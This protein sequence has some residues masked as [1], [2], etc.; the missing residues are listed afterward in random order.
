[1]FDESPITKQKIQLLEGRYGLYLN[2]GE[3]NASLPKGLAADAVTKEQALEL[4]AARAA[5]GP[6]KKSAR[7]KAPKKS[8]AKKRV[9]AARDTASSDDDSPAEDGAKPAK[10]KAVK[11]KAVKKKK[12]AKKGATKK[13]VKKKPADS[14]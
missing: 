13:S 4:L 9:V 7:R 11:K 12:A 8:P 5:L 6:S 14:E 10:K 2:D 3:T 1:V